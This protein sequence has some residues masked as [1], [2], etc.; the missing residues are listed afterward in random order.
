MIATKR[1]ENWQPPENIGL[2]TVN[3][4]DIAEF[5]KIEFF[6]PGP[7]SDPLWP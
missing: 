6:D 3:L 1:F 2:V 4:Y 5:Q 7:G